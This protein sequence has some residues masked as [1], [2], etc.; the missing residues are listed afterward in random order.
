MA[1]A[2]LA[3]RK[4]S[5]VSVGAGARDSHHAHSAKLQGGQK[6][7]SEDSLGIRSSKLPRTIGK[8]FTAGGVSSN[9]S[10]HNLG[11]RVGRSIVIPGQFGQT[12]GS[13]AE[14]GATNS[15]HHPTFF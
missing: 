5:P 4:Q 2:A 9:A 3:A 15:G 7:K 6:P 13:I 12:Q 14:V 10:P 11:P 1:M 8:T